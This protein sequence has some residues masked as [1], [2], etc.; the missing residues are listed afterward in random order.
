VTAD[1]AKVIQLRPGTDLAE[2]V[3]LALDRATAEVARSRL[4][5]NSQRAYVYHMA[6]YATWLMRNARLHPDAFGDRIGAEGAVTAWKRHLIEQRHA[7]STVRVA[8]SAVRVLYQAG[9][10]IQVTVKAPRQTKPGEPPALDRGQ[11]GAVERAADRSG[12]RNAAII[13]VLLYAGARVEECAR[14]DLA[15]VAITERTGTVRL[16]GKGDEVRQ[17]PLPKPARDRITAWLQ[18]RGREPGPLWTSRSG[19]ALTISGVTKVVIKVGEAAG[20]PGTLRPHV[21]R[22]TYATRLRQGGADVSQIQALLGHADPATSARY[23]RAGQA[24]IAATVGG[25]FDEPG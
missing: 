3:K 16:H 11:A 22:H 5:G 10:N 19:S 15:D 2:T 9:A 7:T 12:P 6:A 18:V 8:L 14:L 24:E 25:V 21:L 23:F 4:A 1:G 20:V 13:A 17:V